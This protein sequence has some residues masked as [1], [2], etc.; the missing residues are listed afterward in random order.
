MMRKWGSPAVDN[1]REHFTYNSQNKIITFETFDFFTGA[2]NPKFRTIYTYD[3]NDSLLTSE[4]SKYN[5][6]WVPFKKHLFNYDAG[7]RNDTLF[8]LDSLYGYYRY[9]SLITYY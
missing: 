7:I 1:Y 3:I 6:I 8:T 2:W 5:H 4:T 9:D